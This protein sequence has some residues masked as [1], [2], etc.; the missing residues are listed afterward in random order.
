MIAW[1]KFTRSALL[2]ATLCVGGLTTGV[3]C[4]KGDEGEDRGAS[5]Q[6]KNKDRYTQPNPD[7]PVGEGQ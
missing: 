2:I 7:K 3:G 4:N 1:I 5:A 6:Q